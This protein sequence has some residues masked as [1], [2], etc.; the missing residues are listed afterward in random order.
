MGHHNLRPGVL[1]LAFFTA[2]VVLLVVVVHPATG[3]PENVCRSLM[4]ALKEPER[5][6][7]DAVTAELKRHVFRAHVPKAGS[8]A[9]TYWKVKGIDSWLECFSECCY[10]APDRPCDVALFTNR[11]CFHLKCARTPADACKPVPSQLGKH[12][13]TVM[14][15]LHDIP[16]DDAIDE[17]ESNNGTPGDD[18]VDGVEVEGKVK[19]RGK[20]KIADD[21]RDED[22]GNSL[23]DPQEG[24]AGRERTDGGGE[25]PA[26]SDWLNRKRAGEACEFGLGECVRNAACVI[27]EGS[28]SRQG[29]C[30]CEDGFRKSRDGSRFCVALE[31]EDAPVVNDDDSDDSDKVDKVDKEDDDE[32]T[33]STI[34]PGK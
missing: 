25:L 4:A 14:V 6:V 9:G 32:V 10:P 3:K 15:V 21:E 16:T 2:A 18:W 17:D 19:D 27:R 28:R 8:S 20:E 22:V 34:P 33:A 7:D 26:T 30:R 11:K 23:F 31:E 13:S 5:D 24:I 12:N 29:H 1:D